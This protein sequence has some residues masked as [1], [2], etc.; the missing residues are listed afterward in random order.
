[1]AGVTTWQ[2]A[3]A[4]ASTGDRGGADGA[5]GDG[6]ASAGDREGLT[7]RQG[8]ACTVAI[9]GACSG[10]RRSPGHVVSPPPHPIPLRAM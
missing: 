4:R 5:A 3:L 8:L 1:M 7:A 2:A 10:S 6:S 9:R